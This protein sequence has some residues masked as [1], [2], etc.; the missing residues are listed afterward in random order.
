[1][2]RSFLLPSSRDDYSVIL[3]TSSLETIVVF[4]CF[5]HQIHASE[6]SPSLSYAAGL[7]LRFPRIAAVREDKPWQDCLTVTE[8]TQLNQQTEVSLHFG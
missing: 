4:C 2:Y 1:M 6:I 3:Q 8:L 7:T 5:A